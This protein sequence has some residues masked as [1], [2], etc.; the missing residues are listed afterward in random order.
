[1]E[2][3]DYLC[4]ELKRYYGFDVFRDG[5]FELVMALLCNRDAVGIMATGQ[6]KSICFQLPALVSGKVSVCIS[7]LISLMQDQVLKLNASVGRIFR[8]SNP[9]V[10]CFLGTGQESKEEGVRRGDYLFVYITPE[11]LSTN[12]LSLLEGLVRTHGLSS[13][14]VDEGEHVQ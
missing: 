8:P 5:Q 2:D 13:I 7:P 1:M 4:D 6:G 12:G 11:K 14:C 9:E 10:A 3:P